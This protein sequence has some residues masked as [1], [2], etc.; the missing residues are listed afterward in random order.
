MVAEGAADLPT[1][2]RGRP[3]ALRINLSRSSV[4]LRISGPR[5]FSLGERGQPVHL[6]ETQLDAPRPGVA[7]DADRHLRENRCPGLVERDASL[8]DL[9][10]V[11]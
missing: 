2:M 5:L 11:R 6:I 1:L 4:T 9:D 8:G 10:G 7:H 3:L